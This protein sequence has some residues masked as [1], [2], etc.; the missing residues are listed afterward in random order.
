MNLPE[1]HQKKLQTTPLAKGVVLAFLI[2]LLTLGQSFAHSLFIQS[3]RYKVSD[4]KR[5]PFF[6]GYGHCIPV[7]DGVR[8]K[9]LNNIR[10]YSPKGEVKNVEIRDETCL[11]SYMVNYDTPGTWMLAAQTNP[12]Y[13]T[14][15]TDKKGKERHAIKSIDKIRDKAASIEK[16]FYSKQ[17]TKT[18][19][20]CG[21]PSATPPQKAGFVL[22]LMPKNDMFSLKPGQTLELIVLHN[23]KPF[24]GQGSWDATYN[25]FSTESEDY[26]FPKTRVSGSKISIP[27]PNPGRWYIRYSVKIPA[28][29]VE[30]DKY[31]EMKLTATLVFQINNK[32]KKTKPE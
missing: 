4:G 12:G 6:F 7:D 32:P 3:S 20:V 17:Y 18:Y 27:I 11:H 5:S 15:Y 29:E 26:F 1:N 16:S 31:K 22:E 25:G 13:Y 8:S 2:L 21:A 30:K 10:I 24:E 9:K 28:P 19:V 14:V 23:G